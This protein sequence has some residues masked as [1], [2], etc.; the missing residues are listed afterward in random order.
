M[1]GENR[2]AV[3][4]P[5]DAFMHRLAA[6]DTDACDVDNLGRSGSDAGDLGVEDLNVGDL[7][8]VASHGASDTKRELHATD[9]VA[10]GA[11]TNRIRHVTNRYLTDFDDAPRVR[12]LFAP[13]VAHAD[14]ITIR[15]VLKRSCTGGHREVGSDH[16][17]GGPEDEICFREN[18]RHLSPACTS[19]VTAYKREQKLKR[20]TEVR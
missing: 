19:A 9:D 16:A 4:P 2:N 10:G 5:G 13:S 12:T 14:P 7:H 1:G 20:V 11:G 8:R 18:T 17:P 6:P 15:E 3:F